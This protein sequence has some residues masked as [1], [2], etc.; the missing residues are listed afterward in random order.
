MRVG[1]GEVTRAPASLVE[2]PCLLRFIDALTDAP[3]QK[4]TSMLGPRVPLRRW[5]ARAA[6]RARC[7]ASVPG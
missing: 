1:D 7:E 5:R 6:R 2:Q 3:H 4:S